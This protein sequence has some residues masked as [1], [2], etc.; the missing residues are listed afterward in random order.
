LEIVEN[1]HRVDL[2]KAERDRHLKR[3]KQATEYINWILLRDNPGFVVT[4]QRRPA[5]APLDFD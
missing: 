2:S 5:P 3:A 1:P 4:Q